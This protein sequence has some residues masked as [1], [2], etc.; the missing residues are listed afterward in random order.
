MLIPS[1]GIESAA[2]PG[3][4]KEEVDRLLHMVR[5]VFPLPLHFYLYHN[6]QV[7]VGGGPTGIELR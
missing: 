5:R 6:Q 1:S 3:Q 2:F 7:V 4:V